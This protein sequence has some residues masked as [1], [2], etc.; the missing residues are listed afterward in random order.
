[1]RRSTSGIVAT[2][3]PP[4]V[5]TGRA[6]GHT[7]A[8]SSSTVPS[9]GHTPSPKEAARRGS[10]SGIVATKA[11]PAVST[12]QAP[13]HTP[14]PS[15]STIPSPGH[16]PSPSGA[17]NR[18]LGAV[19]SITTFIRAMTSLLQIQQFARLR[20]TT[21]SLQGLSSTQRSARA[22]PSR[23]LTFRGQGTKKEPQ[24]TIS[25]HGRLDKKSSGS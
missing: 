25:P 22:A 4:A 5:S 7:P 11:P 12:G 23:D 9:Q 15:S 16:T 8:P 6:P 19:Y 18:C 14:A 24:K 10:T 17:S 20:S 2:K 1:L 13:G 3:A 21:C